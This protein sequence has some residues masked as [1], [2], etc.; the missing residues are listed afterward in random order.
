MIHLACKGRGP[1]MNFDRMAVRYR[2]NVLYPDQRE[3]RAELDA[4]FATQDTPRTLPMAPPYVPPAHPECT[5]WCRNG[6]HDP[7]CPEHR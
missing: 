7:K 6:W 3:Y 5:R 1:S 2:D 4:W